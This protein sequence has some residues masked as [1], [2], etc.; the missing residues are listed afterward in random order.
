VPNLVGKTL[1]NARSA[2]KAA[3]FTGSITSTNGQQGNLKVETQNRTPGAC[4]PAT[5]TITVTVS[6]KP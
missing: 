5:T 2:W 6:A 1:A 3:G 4:M